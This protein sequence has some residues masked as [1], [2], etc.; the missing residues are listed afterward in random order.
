MVT[1]VWGVNDTIA[2]RFGKVAELSNA[3]Y[4]NLDGQHR[5]AAKAEKALHFPGQLWSKG[6]L[7][8]ILGSGKIL[9]RQ[10]TMAVGT[11]AP[12]KRT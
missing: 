11:R 3:V 10:V 6:L 5:D 2:M 9:R 12:K 7:C 8:T 1:F 4:R